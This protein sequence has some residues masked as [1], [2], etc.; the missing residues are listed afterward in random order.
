MRRCVHNFM[1]VAVNFNS[2]RRERVLPSCPGRPIRTLIRGPYTAI[3][4]DAA[5]VTSKSQRLG[6]AAAAPIL[7]FSSSERARMR[8]KL[9]LPR[10]ENEAREAG[11]IETQIARE[12]A[13][14]REGEKVTIMRAATQERAPIRHHKLRVGRKQWMGAGERSADSVGTNA[15]PTATT[16]AGIP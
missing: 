11:P 1:G 2:S 10:N 8:L 4:A 9:K 15:A 16:L 13:R 12:R 14:E 6:A 3:T 5:A 7:L